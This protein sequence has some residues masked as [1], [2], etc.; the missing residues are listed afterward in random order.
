M[1]E[2]SD[3]EP[4][5]TAAPG[6]GSGLVP[7]EGKPEAECTARASQ[8]ASGDWPARVAERGSQSAGTRAATG[9]STANGVTEVSWLVRADWSERTGE[10]LRVRPGW[11]DLAVQT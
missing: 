6:C 11:S 8:P 9:R 5:S 3:R 7:I 2:R 4:G 1:E 10:T